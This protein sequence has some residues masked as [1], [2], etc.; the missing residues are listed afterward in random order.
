MSRGAGRIEQG[1]RAAITAQGG[2]HR[3]YPGVICQTVFNTD[4]PTR[5]QRESVLRAF[6]RIIRDQ[7]GWWREVVRGAV[8]YVFDGGAEDRPK[9]RRTASANL[10]ARPVPRRQLQAEAAAKRR[11]RRARRDAVAAPAPAPPAARPVSPLLRISDALQ[12]V[13]ASALMADTLP[14][15]QTAA[16]F[17]AEVKALV[18]LL[19]DHGYYEVADSGPSAGSD[20]VCGR[21]RRDRAGSA[22]GSTATGSAES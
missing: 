8:T 13:S 16:G 18:Q 4:T 15:G 12:R 14:D 22:A 6:R 21:A 20:A 5:A 7:P 17:R 10:L 2:F 9:S 3:Y 11:A 19:Q 1:V